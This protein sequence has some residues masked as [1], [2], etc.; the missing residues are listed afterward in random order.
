MG[1]EGIEHCI[2][3]AQG[4]GERGYEEMRE[5][6]L[7]VGGWGDQLEGKTLGRNKVAGQT[8]SHNYN[9]P[10]NQSNNKS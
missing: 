9:Q 3:S 2:N 5:W 4:W 6:G 7:G 1:A 10:V 8:I